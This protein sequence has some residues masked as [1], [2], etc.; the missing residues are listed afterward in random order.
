[1][2]FPTL[3]PRHDRALQHLNRLHKLRPGGDEVIALSQRLEVAL[4]ELYR[5]DGVNIG[6]NVGKAASAAIAEHLHMHVLPRSVANTNFMTA[7][8]ETRMLPESLET[9]YSG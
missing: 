5:P 3:W 9:T 7:I 6:M 8:G 1:M 2:P 4:I